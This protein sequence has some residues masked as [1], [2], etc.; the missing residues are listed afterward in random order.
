MLHLCLSPEQK[1]AFELWQNSV[2]SRIFFY[3]TFSSHSSNETHE[4]RKD[5]NLCDVK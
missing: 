1:K 2:L 5:T 3:L 4:H